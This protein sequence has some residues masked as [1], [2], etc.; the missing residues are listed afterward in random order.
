VNARVGSNIF[1]NIVGTNGEAAF[2]NDG[3]KLIDFCIFLH[4]S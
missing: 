2:N 1:A 3:R 4:N